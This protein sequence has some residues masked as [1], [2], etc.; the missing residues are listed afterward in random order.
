MNGADGPRAGDGDERRTRGEET[1]EDVVVR[2]NTRTD[3]DMVGERIEHLG[4][5][6][7]FLMSGAILLVPDLPNPWGAWLIGTGLILVGANLTQYVMG[8]RA[9]VFITGAG[10]IAILAGVAEY[11]RVDLPI[12]ALGLL[13]VGAV[14]LLKPVMKR[15][16]FQ[17]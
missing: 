6:V 10:V 15:S 4:W 2:D 17:A 11:M 14:I 1:M 3:K 16:S 8:L 5:A 12:L 7:F 13:L 9:S